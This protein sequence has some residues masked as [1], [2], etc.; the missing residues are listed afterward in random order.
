MK[1]ISFRLILGFPHPNF[2]F[3]LFLR[4]DAHTP[5][6]SASRANKSDMKKQKEVEKS[7]VEVPK[8]VGP[9]KRRPGYCWYFFNHPEYEVPEFVHCYHC[10]TPV[11][12][13]TSGS[14]GLKQHV[15][16]YHVEERDNYLNQAN[17]VPLVQTDVKSSLSK[18][19]G[20]LQ[21]ISESLLV[22]FVVDNNQAFYVSQ[23][24]GE[25]F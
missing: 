13:N 20:F 10:R 1:F 18:M 17:V 14:F 6:H 11:K 16:N 9:T 4:I 25:R 23:G 24:D 12:W 5:F 19:T 7:V 2:F 21:S 15:D 3:S 8:P 22:D